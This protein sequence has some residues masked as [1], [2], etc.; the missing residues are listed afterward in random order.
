MNKNI[1]FKIIEKLDWIISKICFLL[2]CK[3]LK[4]FEIGKYN[5][6]W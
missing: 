2:Y 5:E 1:I 3:S 4:Q 6:K